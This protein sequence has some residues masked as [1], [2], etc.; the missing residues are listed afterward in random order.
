MWVNGEDQCYV[1]DGKYNTRE[2]SDGTLKLRVIDLGKAQPCDNLDKN[3]N[4]NHD[5]QYVAGL[6]SSRNLKEFARGFGQH[7]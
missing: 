5:T 6:I 4:K 2:V 1:R 3:G 7:V